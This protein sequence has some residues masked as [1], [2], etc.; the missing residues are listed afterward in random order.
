MSKRR[1]TTGQPKIVSTRIIDSAKSGAA[2]PG[3]GTT[4]TEFHSHQERE[5]QLQRRIIT[6]TLIALGVLA[7]VLA[8]TFLIDQVIRPSQAVA[9]VAGQNITL[10][11]FQKRVRL[12]RFLRNQQIQNLV[13]TYQQFGMQEQQIVQSLLQEEWVQELQLPDQLGLTVLDQLV[14]EQLIRAAAA[15]RSVTVSAADVDAAIERYFGFNRVALE[16]AASGEATATVTPT[17]TPT[18]FITA[19]PSPTPT[20]AP[21]AELT[22]TP[23]PTPLPTLPPEPTQTIGEQEDE[24][25]T[26][27]D[28]YFRLVRQQTSLSEGD[29]R[30]YFE[31]RALRQALE[32]NVTADLQGTGLFVN[33]RHILVASEEEAQDVLAA[34]N[35]GESFADLAAAIS[36]DTGSGARGGELGWGPT[37]QFVAEFRTAVETADIG[38]LVGPVQTEFGYHIIQVRAREERPLDENQLANAKASAFNTWLENYRTERAADIQRF[39]NWVDSVPQIPPSIFG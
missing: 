28:S 18:P 12:E 3:K 6:G 20:P 2:A 16:A 8:L 9:T 11:D 17:I 38:T 26:Q 1:Q 27:R 34:L 7:V 15:E 30:A 39:D 31:A 35:T 10:A 32:D 4:S 36:T 19:T 33:A 5:Q 13:Q 37:S 29:I 24:F 22:A 14:D 23:S 25:R 21:T